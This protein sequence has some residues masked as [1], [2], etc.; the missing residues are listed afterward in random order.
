M[1]AKFFT[2]SPSLQTQL[3][4]ILESTWS[5]F[6]AL[7]QNQIAVTWIEYE[8]PYRVNTGGGLSSEEFWKYQPQGASYRGVELVE[9]ASI[10][11]LFYMVAMHSWL[12]QGMAAA[13]PEID[14]ALKNAIAHSSSDAANYLIDVLTGTT[15]GPSLPDGPFETWLSQRNIVNRY[16]Q[17]LAWPE[18]RSIN[19]NQKLW[20]ESPYGRERDF[21][22]KAGS[23]RLTTEATARLM[24]SIVGG[25]AVSAVR[26]QAMMRS[27]LRPAQFLATASQ[28]STAQCFSQSTT[29]GTVRHYAAYTE[30]E[31][32]EGKDIHPYLLVI[33]TE[34]TPENSAA[35]EGIVPFITQQVWQ[36]AVQNFRQAPPA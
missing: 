29:T 10:V 15:S 3:E 34:N 27:M 14:R 12:E 25:V 22:N 23:N 9:P 28:P 33:F 32:M 2:I 24:H 35:M 17:R 30:D 5:A 21:L 1:P 8:P 20:Q 4:A 11:N 13:D 6:P 7:A 19:V 36:A 31:R 18:L 16:F 26:S